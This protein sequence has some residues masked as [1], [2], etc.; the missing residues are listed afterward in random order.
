MKRSVTLTL[1]IAARL[2]P[3]APFALAPV[4]LARPDAQASG[5]A[6]AQVVNPLRAVPRTDLSFGSIVVGVA[7][8]GSVEVPTDGSPARYVNTAKAQCANSSDCIPHRAVF[9]VRGEPGR[10][11]R[12]ALPEQVIAI[13]TR[14][15]VGLPVSG[16]MM[17]SLNSSS[18]K[19]EGLLDDAGRDSFFVGGTLRVPAGTR[20]DVFRADLPVIVTYD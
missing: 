16:I 8:E 17:R 1:R 10:S 18:A 3:L 13:G 15:G 11:Y 6:E 14:T 5:Q 4:A 7:A 9:D 12:V 2:L 20:P 19:G